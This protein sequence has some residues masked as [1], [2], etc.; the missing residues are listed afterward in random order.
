[1]A[2]DELLLLSSVTADDFVVDRLLGVG[3]SGMVV[4]ARCRRVG[5]DKL[6]AV[7]LLF[8]FTSDYSSVVSNSYENEWLLLSR[9]LPHQHIV[10][11]WVQFISTIPDSFIQLAPPDISKQAYRSTAGG[12]RVRRKAQFL[13]LDYHPATLQVV[14]S[15]NT[16][17]ITPA[18]V[19]LYGHQLLT[20]VDYLYREYR[21]CHLDIKLS[22]LLVSSQGHLLLCDFGSAVQFTDERFHMQ[23]RQGMSIGGNRAHLAPEVLSAHYQCRAS[24]RGAGVIDYSKQPSFAV[25]VLL[26]EIATGE[27]PLPD[28]PLGWSVHGGQVTYSPSDIPALPNCYPESVCSLVAGLLHPDPTQ[29]LQI[30]NAKE[31]IAGEVLEPLHSGGVSVN[32]DIDFVRVS[33]LEMLGMFCEVT[34]S[35]QHSSVWLYGQSHNVKHVSMSPQPLI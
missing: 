14:L 31:L 2:T 5:R 19:L 4:S 33:E 35:S 18:Q 3:H 24:D 29:R 7:K 20:A 10:R 26:Y 11:Y 34:C 16:T 13:V 15:R 28:Y 1:M 9:V 8:N 21:M 23:W 25:G 30:V 6:Y 27:H 12:G 22:N 17:L 32:Q